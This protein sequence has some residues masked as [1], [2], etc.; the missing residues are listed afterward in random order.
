M[1]RRAAPLEPVTP[2]LPGAPRV[3]HPPSRLHA[4]SQTLL[5]GILAFDVLDR[6]TGDWCV[7]RRCCTE[8]VLVRSAL[9][10][11]GR[12]SVI[13]QSWFVSFA[14]LILQTPVLWLIVSIVRCHAAVTLP[15]PA[16]VLHMSSQS[17]VR[18]AR[19]WLAGVLARVQFR[20][21]LVRVHAFYV[22]LMCS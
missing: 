19:A 14:T 13:S 8:C 11:L 20:V 17:I 21:P 3:V 10:A 1:S 2:N 18:R 7:R 4:R 9:R 6:I 12:R 22:I 15:H 5:A 16:R